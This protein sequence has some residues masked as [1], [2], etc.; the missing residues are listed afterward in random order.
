MPDLNPVVTVGQDGHAELHRAERLEINALR[1][2]AAALLSGHGVSVLGTLASTD[3]LPS[4][5][6]DRDA[7]IV[8]GD[9][10]VW[11]DG[12][13]ENVGR[14]QGPQ[15]EEGPQGPQG[16]RGLQGVAGPAGPTGPAGPQGIPGDEGPQGPQGAGLFITDTVPTVA[17]LPTTGAP[18][19]S[20]LVD[21]TS[22]LWTWNDGDAAY[23]NLGPMSEGP[24][25]PTGPRGPQGP[26]GADGAQ[27]PTGPAGPEGPQGEQGPQGP[28]GS[29]ASATT[30]ASAL[31]SG[32]LAVAR[33]PIIPASKIG[34]PP[35]AT[36]Q[37]LA[38]LSADT[39]ANEDL[40]TTYRLG[41]AASAANPNDPLMITGGTIDYLLTA[42]YDMII[43]NVV[44]VFRGN[45][46]ADANLYWTFELAAYSGVSN[47]P[48]LATM[49]T[50]P[51]GAGAGGSISDG[52]P[53]SFSGM[54]WL[55]RDLPQGSSLRLRL[56]KVGGSP[57]F[58]WWG[59]ATTRY[60]RKGA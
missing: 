3:D 20:Y 57:N 38:D 33:L 32:T 45:F 21:E 47:P 34:S 51:K 25:G 2:R 44:M 58:P 26:P 22:E 6:A 7:W 60:Q 30:D 9:L 29:D 37:D 14:V 46:T 19:E 54:T 24:P 40:C 5:G 15:G 4:T 28:P 59:V 42:D 31:T 53:Y 49:T 39:A 10:W 18:G 56:S 16:P 11:L 17:D 55:T 27:G 23:I 1:A 35:W 48:I 13:W 52:V 43:N 36:T 12:A 50:Q 8:T 41:S